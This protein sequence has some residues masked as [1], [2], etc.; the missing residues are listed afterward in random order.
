M[1][2]PSQ[3]NELKERI[4]TAPS[5]VITAHRNPDADALGSTLGLFHF[6]KRI[7]AVPVVVLLPDPFPVF[8]SWMP[9]SDEIRIFDRDP[10]KG[11]QL[12]REA[13]V[14]F[15]LDYN[16]PARTAKMEESLREAPALKVMIDHHQQPD[17]F[18]QLIWS[19]PSASSTCELIVH[20]IDLLGES[21]R[22]DREIATCLYT[23]IMTDT[24]SFRFSATTAQTH[25]VIA[26]LMEKGIQHWKIHEAIFNQNSFDK[27]R[28][29]GHALSNK[30]TV[31]PGF[32]T[33]YIALSEEELKQYNYR[34]GD[35]EG[36]VNY[37]LSIRGMVMG[38]LFTERNG[39]IRI[40]FRSVGSF[41]VD[42][43]ARAHFEGG[44]HENA[45][46][47]TSYESLEAT[48]DRF[49]QLLPSWAEAL[50]QH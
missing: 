5:I 13:G 44:G 10:E 36:L 22:I 12:L 49:I 23:G 41:S 27:L 6:L 16:H 31:L 25:H 34:E 29:W 47:G 1:Y 24:G 43:F 33:A 30:L 39:K 21:D 20:F 38:A 14:I 32:R 37:A 2:T 28:L 45:A 11:K 9:G 50:N 8:L 40:S 15:C 18:A 17:A 42:R 19:D 3:V 48:V 4:T 26:R 35:L 7:S 46:G